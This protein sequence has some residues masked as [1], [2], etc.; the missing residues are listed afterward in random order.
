M[1]DTA[2]RCTH[3][4]LSTPIA[5][6]LFSRLFRLPAMAAGILAS[7]M[8]CVQAADLRIG[9]SADVTTMDPH[10]LTSQPNLTV[11]YH[12]FDA[13]TRVDEKTQLIPDPDPMQD[14]RDGWDMHIAFG[15]A[16]PGL[17]AIMSSDPRPGPLSPAARAGLEVL[18]RRIQ[19]VA[20]A[21]LLAVSEARAVS[22]LQAV[23]TGTVLTLLG[24][25]PERR[26]TSLADVAREAVLAAIT[27]QPGGPGSPGPRSAAAT[28]RADL[29][30]TP[31]LSQGERLL[32]AELLDRIA[33]QT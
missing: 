11:G 28:L 23:G 32:M 14:L 16:H 20:R 2:A 26:D 15:L 3:R 21:G 22:L 4:I 19:A 17:F 12:V 31:V 7:A 8:F 29:D 30:A 27:V 33:D 13:L 6:P 25:P 1:I 18:H 10:F 24:Q 9:L 5:R